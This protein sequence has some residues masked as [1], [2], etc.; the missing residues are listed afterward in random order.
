[1][2][3]ASAQ[4]KSCA[5]LIRDS[6]SDKISL[7]KSPLQAHKIIAVDVMHDLGRVTRLI[8]AHLPDKPMSNE[9]LSAL[10]A[11]SWVAKPFGTHMSCVLGMDANATL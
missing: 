1:M 2:G 8:S 11:V 10:Q 6:W 7:V 5:I 4:E 9:Y 3:P